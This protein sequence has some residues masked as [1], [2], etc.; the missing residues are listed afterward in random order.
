V[1]ALKLVTVT[2]S[3]HKDETGSVANCSGST[4]VDFENVIDR[5]NFLKCYNDLPN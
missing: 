2:R 3:D 4:I 5:C 1:P